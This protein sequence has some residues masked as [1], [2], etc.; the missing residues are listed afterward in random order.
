SIGGSG[1]GR[2]NEPEE[3][4]GRPAVPDATQVTEPIHGG[5]QVWSVVVDGAARLGVMCVTLPVLDEGGRALADSLAGVVAALLVTRGQCTDAYTA[6]RRT[7]KFSLAA[8]MQW[9]LL[10][11]LSLDSG[12]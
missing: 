1:G 3:H 8:E 9:E 2:P 10:P 4:S 11:P 7:E 5:V 12:R 6:I